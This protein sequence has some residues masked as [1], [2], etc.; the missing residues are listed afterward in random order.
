MVNTRRREP[1]AASIS[2][3]APVHSGFT[4]TSRADAF[5]FCFSHPT[6]VPGCGDLYVLLHRAS[7][8]QGRRA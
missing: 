8:R 7:R 4:L 1:F 2:R 5:H 3:C 6:Q